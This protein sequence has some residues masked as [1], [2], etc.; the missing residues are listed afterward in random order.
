MRIIFLD[1]SYAETNIPRTEALELK[2]K[3]K[4]DEII[5]LHPT[6]LWL[7]I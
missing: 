3:Y 1:T 6:G 7:S 2:E 5:E 4:Q